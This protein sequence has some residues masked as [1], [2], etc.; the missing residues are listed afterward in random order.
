MPRRQ[1]PRRKR[2]RRSKTKRR[3]P[4]RSLRR[5]RY[6]A[7]LG[8][9]RF[10]T[11]PKLT[12]SGVRNE[13]VNWTPEN[14]LFVKDSSQTYITTQRLLIGDTIVFVGYV[15]Q[16]DQMYTQTYFEMGPDEELFVDVGIHSGVSLAPITI[17]S[18]FPTVRISPADDRP[19]TDMH[20][21]AV[22]SHPTSP[23]IS[24]SNFDSYPQKLIPTKVK[25]RTDWVY[26]IYQPSVEMFT[27]DTDKFVLLRN[28]KSGNRVFSG[29]SPSGG[30]GIFELTDTPMEDY[31]VVT[32]DGKRTQ[33]RRPLETGTPLVTGTNGQFD[34]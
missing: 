21:M 13:N 6:R 8:V 23:A 29:F 34:A 25:W 28:V 19:W 30:F 12:F 31:M 20:P 26:G 27:R 11:E 9:H 18:P 10:V 32:S 14:V 3:S 22:P 2:S 33:R 5:R 1:S 16:R 17:P 7:S 24:G 4:K 15:R